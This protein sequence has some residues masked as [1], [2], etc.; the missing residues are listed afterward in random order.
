MGWVPTLAG[1]GVPTLAG[2]GGTYLGW[3]GRYLPFQVG[4]PTGTAWRMLATQQAVCLLRSHRR[5][6]LLFTVFANTWNSQAN[7]SNFILMRACSH[8]RTPI[9]LD[10]V[11]ALCQWIGPKFGLNGFQTHSARI[12]ARHHQHNVKTL[13]G[14]ISGQ[15]GVLTC[16]QA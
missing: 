11:L 5:T 12:S 13:W 14:R 9:R 10:K 7:T 15:I 16:E 4:T 1:W 8:I 2:V 6:F 3:G